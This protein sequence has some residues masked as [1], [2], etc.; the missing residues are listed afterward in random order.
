MKPENIVTT[1]KRSFYL[2]DWGSARYEM[3]PVSDCSVGT[4]AYM[5]LR[6]LEGELTLYNIP[7]IS[8]YPVHKSKFQRTTSEA[9]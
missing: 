4:P 2:I 1:T 6:V 9:T 5:S 3:D 8:S 7:I